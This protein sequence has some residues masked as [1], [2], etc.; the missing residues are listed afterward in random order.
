MF[1]NTQWIATADEQIGALY[2]C[3]RSILGSL[4]INERS[5]LTNR[6][7]RGLHPKLRAISDRVDLEVLAH[8]PFS[9]SMQWHM[10]FA[11][12]IRDWLDQVMECHGI[13]TIT[14]FAPARFLGFLRRC[15]ESDSGILLLRGEFAGL[16]PHQIAVHPSVVLA[17]APFRIDPRVTS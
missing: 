3:E 15:V 13:A 5:R 12:E 7:N 4:R 8:A 14:V 10:R 6:W 16:R 17:T 9:E 1:T 11:D 2:E